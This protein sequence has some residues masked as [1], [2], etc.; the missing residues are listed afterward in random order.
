MTLDL[1]ALRERR[2]DIPLLCA[3]LMERCRAALQHG[4]AQ[5]SPEALDI[6]EAHAWPGNVRQLENVLK[7]AMV[8]ARGDELAPEHVLALLELP[9]G[10]GNRGSDSWLYSVASLQFHAARAEFQT[11]FIRRVLRAAG[12]NVSQAAQMMTLDR[13]SLQR[14][15]QE[16]EIDVAEFRAGG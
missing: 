7:G 12:G 9:E 10:E 14:K 15:A 13:R 4:I 8:L 5:I 11:L 16:Y 2:S 6:L 1:P 3:H